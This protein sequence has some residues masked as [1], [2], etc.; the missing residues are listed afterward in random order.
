M[1]VK[2][3][4]L[5]IP[6]DDPFKNDKL[7]RR[8]P[9]EILT[10]L[11][12]S[13]EGPCVLA[14]DAEWGHGK[15]TFLR[16]WMQ[17][18]RD[19][20]FPVIQFNAWETDYSDDPLL[21]LT[22]ELTEGL[23]ELNFNDELLKRLNKKRNELLKQS[24]M[25]N[26]IRILTKGIID[27]A[28]LIDERV[29]SYKHTKQS[30]T[31]FKATLAETADESISRFSKPLIIAIDELDRC[32]PPYAVELLEVTKHLFDLDNIIFILAVNRS[33]LSK[34]IKVLYGNDFDSQEYLRRFF[35]IDF[36]LPIPDRTNFIDSLLSS[37]RFNDYLSNTKNSGVQQQLHDILMLL[38]TLFNISDIGL[39]DIEQAIYRLGVSL[40]SLRRDRKS[41]LIGMVTA[42]IIRTFAPN[43]YHQ[44]L[45][46]KIEDVEVI[47]ALL[48]AQGY[49]LSAY[50]LPDNNLF[51]ASSLLQAVVILATISRKTQG[52]NPP[53]YERRTTRLLDRYENLVSE[54]DTQNYEGKETQATPNSE[55]ET[56]KEVIN[57]VK[58]HMAY[59][60]RSASNIIDYGF[61]ISTK[62]LELISPELDS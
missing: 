47:D 34:S 21:S 49:E 32:R 54:Y 29:Q 20:E 36:H 1:H 14:V 25:Q 52:R 48:D 57:V 37:T 28:A 10:N 5:E 50:Y 53:H 58:Q 12:E 59:A 43:T 4:E 60:G 35:D 33:Q 15:T 62:R 22:S 55:H 19:K 27:P 40:D 30:V 7:D 41:F 8:E 9:I 23:K 38:R 61:W 3:K 16:F 11:V 2:P 51:Y 26:S 24:V 18:L 6:P 44:F 13:F 42:L 31:D 39:R 46:G 56:A 45:T 17:Y